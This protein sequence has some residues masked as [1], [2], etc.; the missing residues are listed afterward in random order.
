MEAGEKTLTG[1]GHTERITPAGEPGALSV[2]MAYAE[3]GSRGIGTPPVP[4][5]M[6]GAPMPFSLPV[7]RHLPLL[8]VLLLLGPLDPQQQLGAVLRDL[9]VFPE[10]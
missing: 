3:G 7:V 9:V 4:G 6:G 5:G 10:L 8:V 1:N 2:I